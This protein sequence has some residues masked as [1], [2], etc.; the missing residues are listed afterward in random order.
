MSFFRLEHSQW[1]YRADF[2]LYTAASILMGASLLIAS[3]EG[4]KAMLLV[5]AG[6]GLLT[7]PLI[8]YGL[9]RFVLH[10][11]KP[12][13][14]WHA[15]HHQRPHALI[16]TPTILSTALITILVFVPALLLSNVWL[17]LALTFGLLNGY[18][19]Y[20]TTHHAIH[21]WRGQNSWLKQRKLCHALHHDPRRPPGYYGVSSALWDEVLG[22]DHRSNF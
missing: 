19:V 10:G 6:L 16:C 1:A 12:F 7:W 22:T 2:A 3:P 15:A 14:T 4:Q 13:S 5:L 9:H 21:H 8:E 17:A 11:L 20:A 18:L